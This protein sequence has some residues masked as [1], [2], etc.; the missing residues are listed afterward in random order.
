ME[1]NSQINTFENGMN[2]DS[3]IR[4]M[5]NNAYRWAQNVRILTD[6]AGTGNIL[7]NI[8]DVRQYLGGIDI[9]EKILGTA[10][11]RWYNKEKEVIEECGVVITYELYE[12]NHIN[13]I[14]VVTDFDSINPT[15]TLIVSAEIGLTEKLAIVTNYESNKVSKLYL[16]DGLSTIKCINIQTDFNTSKTNPIKDNTYFDILPSATLAPFKFVEYCSGNLPAGMVQYCYQLFNIHG[17]ETT[18]SALSSMI[19]I[20][21]KTDLN[22]NYVNGDAEDAYTDKGCILRASLL[23]DGR[24]SKIRIIR[25]QYT[26]KNQIPRIFI[27]NEGD[28]SSSD[29]IIDFKYSDDGSN[30][31]N[32]I[33]IDKFNNIV[34]F[35]F[36]AKSII[37]MD[38]R[39]FASNIQELTWDVNYDARAY[40]CNKNGTIQLNSSIN[41]QNITTNFN[42]LLS[43]E[44]D[45]LIPSNHDC[46]NPM[47]S[48]LVYPND[49]NE[50]Y[51][52]GYDNSNSIRGG[53]GFNVSYRF[54]V[55]DLLESSITPTQAPNG[56][57]VVSYRLDT[58]VISLYDSS[59]KLKCPE[60]GQ[61]VHTIEADSSFKLKNYANPYYVTNLLGYQRDET[62]RFGIVFYN[63]KNIPSPV[64]WIGDI[65]FPSADIPG[66]EPFTFGDTVNGTGNY[67]LV[68][69]P[70]GILFSVTNIPSEA[71]AYEIVRCERTLNDRTIVAQGILNK[72]VD[73]HGWATPTPDISGMPYEYTLSLG[74]TDRRP[75][76]TPSFAS[77]T[78]A[79]YGQ[80]FYSTEKNKFVQQRDQKV[81]TFDT[82][83]IFDF[84]S[85][86]LSFNKEH[87]KNIIKENSFIVPLYCSHSATYCGDTNNKH[88]RAAI[89]FT[90]VLNEEKDLLENPFGGFI[91]NS[92]V[93]NSEIRLADGIFDGFEDG[94]DKVS[95]GVCKYY[96]FF[97]KSYANKNNSQNRE[98]FEIK[99]IIDTTNISPYINE[100][101]DFKQYVNYIDGYSYVNCCVGSDVSFGPHGVNVAIS[102]PD[103][104]QKGY[105][106]IGNTPLGKNYIYNS[107]LFV[108]IKKNATQYGGNTVMSRSFSVYHSTGTYVKPAWNGYN[109]AVCYG[110]DTYLGIFDYAHSLLFTLNDFAKDIAQ[111]RYVQLYLPV[112]S[113]VNVYFRKDTHF[114]QDVT[115]SNSNNAGTGMANV[116]YMTEPG[117]MNEKYTQ[118]TPMYVYNAAYSCNSSAKNYIQKSLYA[119]DNMQSI[120]RITCS[121]LKTNNEQVDS[122]TK[123]KFANYLDVD[124]AYGQITNLKVFKNKLYYFQ[125]SAVGVASVN[126]RSLIQDNNAGAL[127]LGTGGI[128]TRFD[129]LITLNGDSIVNDKSIVNSET[130]LYWY[131]FDKNVLCAL[132]NDFNELSKVKQVQT[133]LNR[134]PVS[135]RTNPVSFY[136]KKYNEVWFRIYDRS[137]IFNEQLNVFT[138]F[139]THNP[140]WFFPFSTRLVTIKDN[141]CYFLHNMYQ[142]DSKVKEERVSYIRFVVN[143]DISQTKVF[144]NQWFAA[145][146]VDAGDETKPTLITDIHFETRTQETEP[147]DWQTIECREDN[148]RFAISR[149]KQNNPDIQEQTNMSYAGRM[150]GKYLICNY[151]FDCNDNREFK[152]P[153]VKTTYRYSML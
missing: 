92:D 35:E 44:S 88:Y 8:E 98:A 90:K 51:A 131:D 144:D 87:T 147:I 54:V 83:G 14:W 124:S 56:Q 111:K 128:L 52:Y 94:G 123:F 17:S 50:E 26:S 136:D 5:P 69:H 66:Y 120:N 60:T 142:V 122:W 100:T 143:K 86:E 104:Y 58:G 153:Y 29:S 13:N 72:T 102:A 151:T 85:P 106:G 71:K 148:Y 95:G 91:E 19:P 65:R 23:N 126:D 39:I 68:S 9:N 114:A 43:Q 96:Q 89:P 138:S 4:V 15:W 82:Y 146:F 118:T 48:K 47:N 16:S 2:L 81:N 34:P 42:E 109:S 73:F 112:E 110:G 140:N 133:Y 3:D 45:L 139:Y 36:N 57:K 12:G 77:T 149:E 64:H 119:E 10:V 150:R 67:E 53:K 27:L 135:A 141:N 24:H 61:V 49:S 80:G 103:V 99:N 41:N 129:Y 63:E 30:T 134:L 127:T 11:T 132:N 121:E 31:A 22:S 25:I 125:A 55:A 78:I 40:R 145:E 137:L 21:T 152:L 33:S 28:I 76:V 1:I 46:I 70:L 115:Y 113:S 84:V 117:A 32:E 101:S 74:K 20:I 97:S 62:Y 38:N 130:T 79:C 75:T 108:N 6:D 116:Y 105:T 93:S 18:T 59:I 37:K 7:Q 107:V